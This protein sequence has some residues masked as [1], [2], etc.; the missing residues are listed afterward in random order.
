[1]IFN[2][3]NAWGA[4]ARFLHWTMA[5]LILA[6]FVLGWTAVNYPLSPTKLQLFMWHKSTGLLLLGLVALRLGWRLVNTAP[7]PPAGSSRLEIRLARL[8]HTGLYLLMILMPVSGYVINS[9]GNYPLRW[10]GWVR[11]F[12][13]WRHG[14]GRAHGARSQRRRLG[15]HASQRSGAAPGVLVASAV[16]GVSRGTNL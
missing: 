6:M 11:A 10:F 8:G 1:M 9:T 15:R 16:A 12:G 4:P 3:R 2:T 5:V 13:E 7:Q 14:P